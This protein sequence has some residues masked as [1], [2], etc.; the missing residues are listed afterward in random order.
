MADEYPPVDYDYDHDF[1]GDVTFAD[2]SAVDVTD[3]ATTPT[4]DEF[5]GDAEFPDPSQTDQSGENAT[6]GGNEQQPQTNEEEQQ[7]REQ[8]ERED[9]AAEDQQSKRGDSFGRTHPDNYNQPTIG[10]TPPASDRVPYDPNWRE[11]VVQ[12][13]EQLAGESIGGILFGA[14]GNEHGAR[15]ISGLTEALAGTASGNNGMQ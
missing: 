4:D 6:D 10:P 11:E 13:L 12:D 8:R 1:Y 5:W 3:T 15:I 2:P 9:R 14:S 7:K